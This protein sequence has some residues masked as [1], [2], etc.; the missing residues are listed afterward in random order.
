MARKE[1]LSIT[2]APVTL[3]A[4][5]R[6]L[7]QNP[8]DIWMK[9]ND[10]PSQHE[11]AVLSGYAQPTISKWLR[12]WKLPPMRQMIDL[13]KMMGEEPGAFQK[14]WSQWYFAAPLGT[15]THR[16][17]VPMKDFN[18]VHRSWLDGNPLVRWLKDNGYA[19]EDVIELFELNISYHRLYLWLRGDRMP[20]DELLEDMAGRMKIDFQ[21]LRDQ[22][23]R[24][25][26]ANPHGVAVVKLEKLLSEYERKQ[27]KKFNR[28][29]E[30]QFKTRFRIADA[31]KRELE[32]RMEFQKKFRGKVDPAL[33]KIWD[34]RYGDAD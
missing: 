33:Q 28:S 8:L 12:G 2:I 4:L 19:K 30:E 31:R 21:T 5:Q 11:V 16:R 20:D 1:R 3:K 27:M 26:A 13:A 17:A 10:K 18:P 24:W 25:Y 29:A 14:R 7:L 22:W 32:G 34:E 6:W 9:E 23:G 15:R